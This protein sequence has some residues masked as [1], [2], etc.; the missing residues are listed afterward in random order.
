[1]FLTRLTAPQVMLGG[2]HPC[3]LK[4]DARILTWNSVICGHRCYIVKSLRPSVVCK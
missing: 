3:E 1:M 2:V 4:R